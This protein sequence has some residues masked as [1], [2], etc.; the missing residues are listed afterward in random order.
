MHFKMAKIL[1][2][3]IVLIVISSLVQL[4][5]KLFKSYL[6]IKIMISFYRYG[7]FINTLS[8]TNKLLKVHTIGILH[9]WDKISRK[10]IYST[11][12]TFI[13]IFLENIVVVFN[14]V[15][16]LFLWVL[17]LVYQLIMLLLL[18]SIVMLLVSILITF[19]L[20]KMFKIHKMISKHFFEVINN[21]YSL[22]F[23]NQSK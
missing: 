4:T 14:F 18:F 3:L 5:R 2:C 23:T 20:V 17:T 1:S 11:S 7:R 13:S 22:P 12:I 19:K 15:F 6:Y 8:S 21:L 16:K 9:L 10:F